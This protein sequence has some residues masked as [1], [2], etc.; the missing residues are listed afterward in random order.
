MQVGKRTHRVVN[1]HLEVGDANDP[2][3][4][5][6]IVQLL[7]TSELIGF[8]SETPLPLSVLGDFNSSPSPLDPRPAY[9]TMVGSGYLDLWTVRQGPP[10][11]GDTC[12]QA[13]ELR[14]PVSELD[15]RI[16]LVFSRLPPDS[17]LMPIRSSVV[18]DRAKDKSA[19]GLWPSDHAGVVTTLKFKR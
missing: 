9:A 1:T 10:D 8:I 14:N 17:T 19:S 2:G 18:G 13:E 5:V 11:P 15:E 16:D 4:P 7:Q 3:S 12:C 6:N